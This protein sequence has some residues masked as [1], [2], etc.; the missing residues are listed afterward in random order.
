[1]HR[2]LRASVLVLMS[3]AAAAVGFSS[4]AHA[5]SS[6]DFNAAFVKASELAPVFKGMTPTAQPARTDVAST[7]LGFCGQPVP[8]G[9]G[10]SQVQQNDVQGQS[11]SPPAIAISS[12][13]YMVFSKAADAKAA[14]KTADGYA[15]SCNR[16]Y[17]S[18]SGPIV[19]A[20]TVKLPKLGDGATALR[21]QFLLGT[22]GVTANGVYILEARGPVVANLYVATNKDYTDKDVVRWSKAMDKRL[23]KLASNV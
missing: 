21:T 13:S 10:L 16:P 18:S 4:V 8:L 11:S 23:K 5:Q 9:G 15:K 12:N 7:T 20:G 1:M 19:P 17:A 14:V 22:A 6:N 3:V 2:R